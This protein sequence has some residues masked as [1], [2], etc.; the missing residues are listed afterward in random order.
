MIA[1]SDFVL[2][3]WMVLYNSWHRCESA[4]WDREWSNAAGSQWSGEGLSADLK[5]SIP[6]DG[7][8]G[9]TEHIGD[10]LRKEE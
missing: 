4:N 3:V 10:Y 5:A 7:G 9:G 1:L 6:A 8:S 2:A